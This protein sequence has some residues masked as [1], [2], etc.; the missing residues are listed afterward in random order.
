MPPLDDVYAT[1][2]S[3]GNPLM[4]DSDPTATHSVVDGAQD[5]PNK[6]AQPAGA[7]GRNWKLH[8]APPSCVTK[9]AA[10]GH[11]QPPPYPTATQ[12]EVDV[13]EMLIGMSTLGSGPPAATP[14]HD[15]PPLDVVKI[16]AGCASTAE[17]RVADGQD[18]LVNEKSGGGARLARLNRRRT[19]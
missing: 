5:T 4:P 11:T 1:L 16:I 17:Q 3:G 10:A 19:C 2:S 15:V 7:V 8:E 12:F 9:A 6:V 13:H 14:V 18:T